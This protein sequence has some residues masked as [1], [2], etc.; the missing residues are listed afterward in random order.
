MA[1]DTSGDRWATPM[2]IDDIGVGWGSV[3]AAMPPYD[4]IPDEFQQFNNPW[5]RWQAEWFFRGID[6]FPDAQE[7][8]D[9][10]AATRHLASIQRSME[11]KHEHKQAA[12]AYLASRWLVG[13]PKETPQ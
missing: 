9:K 13:P 1:S 4:A 5:A 10:D 2:A 3:T 12:V 11:P 7:G 8:I 6:G